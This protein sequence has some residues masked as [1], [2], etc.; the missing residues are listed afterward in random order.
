MTP[1][2]KVEASK[3]TPVN[4][5]IRRIELIV[6]ILRYVNH[7]DAKITPLVEKPTPELERL[8]NAKLEHRAAAPADVVAAAALLN[9]YERRCP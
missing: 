9:E 2:K 6:G 7:A 8:F 5:A 1:K 3:S 4:D